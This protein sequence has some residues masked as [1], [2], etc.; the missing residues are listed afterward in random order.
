VLNLAEGAG[1]YSKP[2]KRRYDLSSVG[3]TTE[4]AAIFDVFLRLKLIPVEQH[5]AAKAM[6][7]RV[8]A[9]L[10]KLAK[11]QEDG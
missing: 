1:K 2:D 7:E 3:S 11:A 6:L 8:A 4:S 5:A 10:V 9:M